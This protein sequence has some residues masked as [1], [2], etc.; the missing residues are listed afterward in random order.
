MEEPEEVEGAP[1]EL[2]VVEEADISLVPGEV[3]NPLTVA[4]SASPELLPLTKLTTL[5]VP[6]LLKWWHPSILPWLTAVQ[7]GQAPSV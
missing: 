4:F 5:R 3:E 7:P 1:E 2:A 6:V